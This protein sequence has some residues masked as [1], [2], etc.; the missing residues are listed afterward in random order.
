M[1][2][3]YRVEWAPTGKRDVARLPEKIATAVIEFV[4]GGLVANPRRAGR[5]LHL[6]LTGYYAA[7][8]GDFRVI[9]AID[10]RR[11]RVVIAAISHRADAYR[12]R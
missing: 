8:R 9:Y 4:Y 2:D 5:A 11:R 7:R 10:T 1:A 12:Q 6:E 3:P